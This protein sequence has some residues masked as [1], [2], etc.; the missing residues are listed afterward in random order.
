MNAQWPLR[1]LHA[2]NCLQDLLDRLADYVID[3]EPAA[4]DDALAQAGQEPF[5]IAG[6]LAGLD[7]LAAQRGDASRLALARVRLRTVLQLPLT[8]GPVCRT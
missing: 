4:L 7:A 3:G 8:P 2:M 5:D 6:L 1:I